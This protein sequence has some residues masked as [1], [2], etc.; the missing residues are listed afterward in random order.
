L[1]LGLL[2]YVLYGQWLVRKENQALSEEKALLEKNSEYTENFYDEYRKTTK[3]EIAIQRE[4]L[5][6]QTEQL[7]VMLRE[8]NHR[9]KNNLQMISSL[10]GI[11][12]MK[13][14]NESTKDILKNNKSRIHA[15]GLIHKGIYTKVFNK[16][17]EIK[18]QDYIDN[19]INSLQKAFQ[20][21]TEV[22]IQKRVED[23]FIN[24]DKAIAIGLIINEVVTNTFKHA[25]TD[26]PCPQ[27]KI[28]FGFNN[29]NKDKI[30]LKIEDNGKITLPIH[31]GNQQCPRDDAFG[32][33]FV[34]LWTK[35]LEGTCLYDKTAEGSLRFILS[36]PNK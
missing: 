32:A 4:E 3:A 17:I 29:N 11:Q 35:E 36:I 23:I 13:I 15:I 14:D 28:K 12:A 33:R 26:H 18:M 7:E 16:D 10:L 19:L 2:S 31:N 9:T 24:P 27:L 5:K 20:L 21:N 22:K 34:D 8:L 6:K 1:L 25:F 30:Y